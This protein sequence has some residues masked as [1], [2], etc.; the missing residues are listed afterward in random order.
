MGDT[1]RYQLPHGDGAGNSHY[2][3]DEPR[4]PADDASRHGGRWTSGGSAFGAAAARGAPTAELPDLLRLSR[5]VLTG[6]GA[7]LAR[8]FGAAVGIAIPASPTDGLI[9]GTAP[10]QPDI[11]F[12]FDPDA[13]HVLNAL[14]LD[15]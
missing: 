10:R 8:L 5:A 2:D 15:S 11:H 4:I 13:G 3:P 12:R 9:E 6:L 1:S 14:G 7:V